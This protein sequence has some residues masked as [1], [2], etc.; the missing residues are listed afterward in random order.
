MSGK[1][2]EQR[3]EAEERAAEAHRRRVLE[4]IMRALIGRPRRE[5]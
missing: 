3:R 5:P 2:E 1:A 4:A